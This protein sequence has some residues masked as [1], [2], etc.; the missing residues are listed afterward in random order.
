LALPNVILRDL[1]KKIEVKDRL[2]LRLS[3]RSFEKLVAETNAG[4]FLVGTITP[5]NYTPYIEDQ[6]LGVISIQFGSAEF[7]LDSTEDKFDQFVQFRERI[8]TGISFDVFVIT[9]RNS[10][11]FLN[12]VRNIIHKFQIK[13]LHIA[14]LET[15]AQLEWMLQ[16]MAD[17][18]TS[19]YHSTLSFLP[20]TAKLLAL[21]QME[22]LEIS[23]F[24]FQHIPAELFFNLLHLHTNLHLADV[25]LTSDEWI[26]A[27][28]ILSSD[29]RLRRVTLWVRGSNVVANQAACGITEAT[30]GGHGG[31]EIEVVTPHSDSEDMVSFRYRKCKVFIDHFY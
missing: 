7:K 3:C 18:P 29:D 27:I 14:N 15:E 31:G 2:R 19:K 26:R 16:V 11:I 10:S 25:V 6:S 17:F 5:A 12:F 28:Q 9:I 4:F 30:E 20:E 22:Y 21:P 8:F 1:L 13:E 23:E 24:D